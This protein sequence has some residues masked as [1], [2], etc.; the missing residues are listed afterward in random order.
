MHFSIFV[1][2]VREASC[3]NLDGETDYD[4]IFMVFLSHLM[5]YGTVVQPRSRLAS[6]P[7]YIQILCNITPVVD[8][9]PNIVI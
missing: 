5:H 1:L 6:P 7:A 9:V 8:T 2:L 3:S 4:L